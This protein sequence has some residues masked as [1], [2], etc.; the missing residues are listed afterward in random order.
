MR[1]IYPKQII[2]NMEDDDSNGELNI[3]DGVNFLKIA[4]MDD[5]C[6]QF[7]QKDNDESVEIVIMPYSEPFMEIRMFFEKVR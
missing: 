7:Y 3:D 2:I 1:M 6:N 5:A 4:V